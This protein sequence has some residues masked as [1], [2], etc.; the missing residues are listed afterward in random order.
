MN[1]ENSVKGQASIT[2]SPPCSPGRPTNEEKKILIIK[3]NKPHN[4]QDENPPTTHLFKKIPE[5]K[6]LI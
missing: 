6:I 3:N 5:N 1:I 4:L 2:I